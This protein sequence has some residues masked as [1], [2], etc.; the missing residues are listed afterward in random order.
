MYDVIIVGGG[1]AGL[2]AAMVLGRCRRKV[3]LFDTGKPRNR[4]SESM[5]GF[6]TR[7]GINPGNFI[8]LG[9]KEL[10]KY[11]VEVHEREIV[12]VDYSSE[13]FK[14][15]DAKGNEYRSKKLLLATGLKDRLPDLPGIEEM[16]GKSVHH[17]PY[18]DGW[19]SRDK[20][21]AAYGR[22]RNGFGL[23]L[24]LKTW[25]NDVMLFT[26]GTNKLTDPEI[27]ELERNGVQL[28]TKKIKRLEGENG[29]LQQIVL[30]DGTSEHREA[31]F[32]STGTEQ[33]SR[34]G[35]LLGC[36]FTSKGVVKTRKLQMTNI[37]GLF[38]AGDSARDVQLVI[39]AAAEGTK[40]AVAINMELQ[41]ESRR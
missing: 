24:S 7:D 4:W 34:L 1:P 31:M 18:C 10:G 14:A 30:A 20:P 22:M 11:G 27:S 8:K 2:S 6:I 37:K 26:D 12:E 9:R 17:C 5:N 15:V 19:E 36:E 32:F 38:V 16:Y 35:E 13:G 28:N 29:R 21:I 25:S 3:A 23:S 33:Q 41:S 39:V 40:A